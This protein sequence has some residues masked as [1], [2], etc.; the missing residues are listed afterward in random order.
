MCEI[1]YHRRWYGEKILAT[2]V[3]VRTNYN[4]LGHSR[5]VYKTEVKG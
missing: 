5:V 4:K 1:I 3:R 2:V